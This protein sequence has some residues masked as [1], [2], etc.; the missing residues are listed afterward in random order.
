MKKRIQILS[1][2]LT[3]MLLASCDDFLNLTPQDSLSPSTYY[4]TAAEVEKAVNGIYQVLTTQGGSSFIL[5]PDVLTDNCVYSSASG[6]EWLAFTKGSLNPST[7]LVEDKWNRDYQGIARA[8]L[9]I[10]NLTTRTDIVISKAHQ[11]QYEGEARFLRAY[12]Y[13]DLLNYYGGVPLILEPKNSLVEYN[14]P[15]STA[16]ETLEQILKDVNR[17]IECMEDDAPQNYTGRATRGAA[18]MLKARVLLYHKRYAEAYGAL[19]QLDEIGKYK[20]MTNFEDVFDPANENNAEVIFDIQYSDP[21]NSNS[22]YPFYTYIKEWAGGYVPTCSLA[23]D[24]YD[25]RGLAPE[26][27]PRKFAD[28]F[29]NRDYRMPVTLT[30]PMDNWGDKVYKPVA[31]DKNYYNSCLKVKKYLVYSDVTNSN[32][33]SILNVIVYRYADALLMK[34][35]CIIECDT[36][37]DKKQSEAISLLDEV[38]NR[39]GMPNVREVIAAPTRDELR[40]IMRRERRCELAFENT[41][42]D[43]IRRW[44]IAEDVMNEPAYGY[45]PAMYEGGM[46]EKY[47][48]EDNRMFLPHQYLWPI[49]Q[50]EMDA[51]IAIKGQ[52]NPGY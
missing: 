37:F 47:I 36:L 9:V 49:P 8:N 2:V 22:S 5:T 43:D 6:S 39:A 21:S 11:I 17:A 20:L 1:F 45:D 23:E 10:S 34:S 25:L 50:C 7:Q 18:L 38:R 51:N 12:F 15:R 41:R 28:M 52:Q 3:S 44:R 30:R 46:W 33:R 13:A 31:K 16:E 35:E 14:L 27:P 32:K 19:K 48:V 29:K 40:E 26:F 4:N 42:Y 24:Y